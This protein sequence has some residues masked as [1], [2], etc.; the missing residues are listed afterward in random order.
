MQ[1]T[2]KNELSSEKNSAEKLIDIKIQFQ[3]NDSVA[4]KTNE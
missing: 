1:D 2:E 4:R 3:L